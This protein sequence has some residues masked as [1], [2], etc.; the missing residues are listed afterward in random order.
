MSSSSS[1]L[2][3][4]TLTE[5]TTLDHEALDDTVELGALVSHALL[6]RGAIFLHTGS[7]STEVLGRL[8]DDVVEE[9]EGDTPGGLFADGD[10][11]L[12]VPPR[13]ERLVYAS[14]SNRGK[15]QK[16]YVR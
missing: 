4:A 2:L 16:L 13:G 8:G 1:T 5:V 10:V 6:E 12:Q 15:K 9:L 3:V 7:Q 14:V 11:K